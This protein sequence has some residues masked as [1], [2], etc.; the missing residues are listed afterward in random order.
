MRNESYAKIVDEI[1]SRFN[2]GLVNA[3]GKP[4]EWVFEI[5]EGDGNQGEFH[6]CDIMATSA[7][8]ALIKAH[9]HGFIASPWD[10]R[11]TKDVDGDGLRAW[12]ASY[13]MPIYSDCCRWSASARLAIDSRNQK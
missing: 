6:R 5:R 7:S 10:V 9:R 2:E 4:M 1:Q 12:A 3:D 13:V 11:I 8:E